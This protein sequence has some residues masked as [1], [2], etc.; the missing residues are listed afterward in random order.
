MSAAAAQLQA[1]RHMGRTLEYQRQA[2]AGGAWTEL[3]GVL[4][5]PRTEE[6]VGSLDHESRVCTFRARHLTAA[7]LPDQ[8]AKGDRIRDP[9]NGRVYVV[10]DEWETRWAGPNPTFSFAGVRG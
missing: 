7:A 3:F 1:F 10:G 9:S 8:P 4:R 2:D 6:L 5:R